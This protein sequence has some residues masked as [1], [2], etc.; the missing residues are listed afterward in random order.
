M[1]SLM[2][3]RL[4]T[5]VHRRDFD[6]TFNILQDLETA[7]TNALNLVYEYQKSSDDEEIQ[8]AIEVAKEYHS[9]KMDPSRQVGKLERIQHSHNVKKV[10]QLRKR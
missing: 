1:H 3:E 10:I 7:N 2:M 5:Q 6:K 8:R 9:G 4:K